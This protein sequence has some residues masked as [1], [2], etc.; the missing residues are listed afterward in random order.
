MKKAIIILTVVLGMATTIFGQT[1]AQKEAKLK[2]QIIALDRSGWEAWKNKDVNWFK[3]NTTPEFM[4]STGGGLSSKAEVIK[5]TP[6]ECQVKSYVLDDFKFF[7]LSETAV[8]LTYTVRQDAICSGKKIPAEVRASVT[9]VKRGGKWL[10][11]FYMDA[12]IDQ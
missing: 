4:T 1:K 2:A 3:N 6:T 5:S 12:T 7:I 9:Y 8:L 10:E 11:A